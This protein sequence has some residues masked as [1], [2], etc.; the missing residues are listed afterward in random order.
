[1]DRSVN[2]D[3]IACRRGIRSRSKEVR[4]RSWPCFECSV[5]S[6]GGNVVLERGK[7]IG[8]VPVVAWSEAGFRNTGSDEHRQLIVQTEYRVTMEEKMVSEN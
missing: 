8:V 7:L 6:Y 2:N 5:S 3:S 1:M 4:G